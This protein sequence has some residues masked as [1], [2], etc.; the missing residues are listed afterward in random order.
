MI[1]IQL[2]TAYL[3]SMLA[4]A[5]E[6]NP[7]FYLNGVHLNAQAKRLEASDGQAALCINYPLP[8]ELTDNVILPT[9]FVKNCVKVA[10]AL[11]QKFVVIEYDPINHEL[12]TTA[13]ID[14]A[15]RGNFPDLDRVLPTEYNL[16]TCAVDAKFITMYGNV[17]KPLVALH[18]PTLRNYTKNKTLTVW[19]PKFGASRNQL[20]CAVMTWG[21]ITFL[22]AGL[23][24][25]DDYVF[26]TA[27]ILDDLRS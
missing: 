7:N 22:I 11:K 5:P 12:K 6:N 24:A 27:S 19:Q 10:K 20:G 18:N 13:H 26:T 8:D 1:T 15:P 3:T 4:V 25:I 2:A 9:Q 21:D 23:K 16:P 14:S 17:M